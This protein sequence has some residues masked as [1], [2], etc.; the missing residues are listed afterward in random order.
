MGDGVKGVNMKMKTVKTFCGTMTFDDDGKLVSETFSP[1]HVPLEG[2]EGRKCLSCYHWPKQ[3]A[4]GEYYSSEKCPC[5]DCAGVGYA[6]LEDLI[7]W[8]A[9]S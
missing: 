2:K 7:G 8:K 3:Q 4:D 5:F 1:G 6:M 9:A